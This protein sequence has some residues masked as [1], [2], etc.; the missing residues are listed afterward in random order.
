MGEALQ[1]EKAAMR[2]RVRDRLEA[3][4]VPER[5]AKSPAACELLERQAL[6]KKARAVLFYAPLPGELDIWPL[7]EK[8]L[9]EGKQIAL[10][11][12]SKEKGIYAACVIGDTAAQLQRGQFGILEPSAACPE[13]ELNGLDFLLVPGIAFDLHGRRLGRGKGFYD[14]LLGSVRG[15]TCGVAFDE[16]IVGEVPLEP[17][18]VTLNCILTPT[19]W[20]E[21]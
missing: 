12:F 19:R 15:K 4:T 10:P 5:A 21:L 13:V 17:H 2:R 20:I 9:R 16:Q 18:D 11:R 1:A 7:M 3:M 6:W 14:L 8:G